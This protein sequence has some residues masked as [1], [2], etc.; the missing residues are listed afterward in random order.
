MKI[1]GMP[2]LVLFRVSTNIL[3]D[4]VAQ[5]FL[6]PFVFLMHLDV[7]SLYSFVRSSGGR[8]PLFL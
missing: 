2:I 5:D 1:L 7:F 4:S 3:I 6:G 8:C